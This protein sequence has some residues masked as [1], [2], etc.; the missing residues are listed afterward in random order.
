VSTGSGSELYRGLGA[1]VLGGL[2]LSTVVTLILVPVVY[3]LGLDAQRALAGRMRW[4]WRRR[5]PA[6]EGLSGASD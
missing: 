5:R 6:L 2:A 3:S 4:P 1:A